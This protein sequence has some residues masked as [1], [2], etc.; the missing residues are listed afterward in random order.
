MLD[1]QPNPSGYIQVRHVIDGQQRLITL[2]LL[3]N[4]ARQVA[5]KH[6]RPRDAALL[7]ALVRNPEHIIDE[8]DELLKLKVWPIL[9]DRTAFQHAM[10]DDADNDAG[11]TASAKPSSSSANA[12]G[13]GPGKVRRTPP[14]TGCE[15][16][17]PPW[18]DISSSW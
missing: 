12:S 6:G 4:A 10:D 8:D 18:P 17:P 5:E 13:T 11:D 14:L 9:A 16:S 7:K 1:Q 3:L 2:Q 15:R